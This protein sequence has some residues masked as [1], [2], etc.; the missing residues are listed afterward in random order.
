MGSSFSSL[1]EVITF[2][3]TQSASPH[4]RIQ[5]TQSRKALRKTVVC[6]KERHLP[7][8]F[9]SDG[10]PFE[11]KALPECLKAM[12]YRFGV[13]GKEGS[14]DLDF[15]KEKCEEVAFHLSPSSERSVVAS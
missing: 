5:S 10:E 15:A 2:Y 3:I 7:K 11:L 4:F 13:C 9:S 8:L 12:R 6:H 14:L 1:S